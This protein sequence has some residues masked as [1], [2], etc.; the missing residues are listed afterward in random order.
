[1]KER[2]PH[3]KSTCCVSNKI[4]LTLVSTQIIRGLRL[5]DRK[6]CHIHVK[7]GWDN[8]PLRSGHLFNLVFTHD[9]NHRHVRTVLPM[10]NKSIRSHE[11][12]MT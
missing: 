6:V 11:L 3:K 2:Y 8:A 7:N 12:M 1:M 5:E 10:H 9:C 4:L